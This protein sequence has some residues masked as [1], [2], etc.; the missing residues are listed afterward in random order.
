MRKLLNIFVER[1]IAKSHHMSVNERICSSSIMCEWSMK[2]HTYI[3][4]DN[5]SKITNIDVIP[6]NS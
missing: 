4:F 6:S 5:L 2:S 1:E 3:E